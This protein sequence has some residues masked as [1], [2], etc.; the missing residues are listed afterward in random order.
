MVVN[1]DAYG[2]KLLAGWEDVFKK[3][4]LTLWIMLALKD[5]PKHMAEIKGFIE[6]ATSGTMTA[7]D[8]SMYRALRRYY[9]AE[10]VEYSTEPGDGGPERKVY[11]L[12]SVGHKVLAEFLKR[13]VTRVFYQPRIKQLIERGTT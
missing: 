10:L 7:D 1:L 3:G 2:Q 8:Q 5:G 12:T 9:D 4:Q 6:V 11:A 13:N